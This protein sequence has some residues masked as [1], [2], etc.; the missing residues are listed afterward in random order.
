MLDCDYN[1]DLFD[2]ETVGRWLGHYETLLVG[3][4]DDPDRTVSALPL[5]DDAER[6]RL[7]W[8]WN[9]TRAEYPRDRRVHRLIE[10]QAG[11]TPDAEAVVFGDRRLSYAELDAAAN[12]L[13]RHLRALGAGPGTRAGVC[14][15]RSPEMLVGLLAILKA[16]AAYV[17]LDP[18]Y[19]GERIEAV[20][21]DAGPALLL[22]QD[23]V[24]SRLG[25]S[26]SRVVLVDEIRAAIARE[27]DRAPSVA[28]GS[29]DLAYLIY[30]SGSTGKPKGV[31]IAH[32]SV[33]NL[34]ASMA[35]EPGIVAG[36]TLLAVTTLA[37]DIAALELWLPLTVGARV[38]VASRE[39]AGDGN[40]LLDLMTSSGTTVL[41][42]TPATWRLLLEAGW[43][44]TAGLKALCGGEA[45]PRD[46]ADALIARASE[47]W[48]M[49]G[50]T[51]TTVWS[52]ASRVEPGPGPVPIGPPIANTTFHVLD[53]LGHPTPIGVPGE[54]HIGGDGLAPGYWNEPGLSAETFIADPFGRD[55]GSRLYRTGD[56]VRRLPSGMLEFL[57]RLDTQVKVRGFRIE[58]SEVESVLSRF[59]G[60]RECVVAAIGDATGEK[61][62]AAYVVSTPPAPSA[63]D[64]RR[65]V[66]S[67]LPGYM[68]PSVFV[69]L[70]ALPR[71]PNGKV[72]RKRLPPP[73]PSAARLG[74]EH[75]A[76][77]DP[78]ERTLAEIC[79]GVLKLDRVGARDDLF[80]LGADSIHL[81]QIVAR[82]RE[83]GIALTPTQILAG[84]TVSA[85]ASDPDRPDGPARVPDSPQLVAVS[86]DRLRTRL[87]RLS[88]RGD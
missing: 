62:L 87:S 18:S 34:L 60:V 48:N 73:D 9:D 76:P 82:A 11:R 26:P 31:P 54:L 59:E 37:F 33:V 28:V 78:R 74:R 71:T 72:D 3:M 24:A 46:L 27:G 67:K 55:P 32:R 68:V 61:R 29:D 8:E 88:T 12:R 80:D 66:A 58:T 81:F 69:P 39:E 5:L 45:L 40:R 35:R 47:V 63:G 56:R 86:R 70:D 30:T 4:A 84:R 13:V 7:V 16:G 41:Q 22:T 10:E 52:A 83:A 43:T 49:Y 25:P 19:P 50:P 36:D 2:R 6:H 14:L 42:A 75:V 15:D 64:L 20:L 23:D 1:T 77:A 65:F 38:V 21:R 51:E 57:G 53:S 17:P 79:A 85:I 44:G